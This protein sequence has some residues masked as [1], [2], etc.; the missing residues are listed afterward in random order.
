[1]KKIIIIIGIIL[2]VL[3]TILIVQNTGVFQS[4]SNLNDSNNDNVNALVS[5]SKTLNLSNQGLTKIPDYIFNQRSLEELNVSDNSLSG[6]IQSQIGQLINLKVLNASNNS[7]TGVPA[8]VGKLQKLEIL[9]LSNN[10]LTGLPN[11]L[12]NLKNLK[13]LNLAGNSYSQQDLDQIR[14]NLPNTNFILK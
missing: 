9:D 2:I 12:G 4:V 10:Q 5:G 7:M 14:A 11:E 1:M 13:T 6:A 3:V 8:E